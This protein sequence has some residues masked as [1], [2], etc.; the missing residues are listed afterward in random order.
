MGGSASSQYTEG[1]NLDDCSNTQTNLGLVIFANETFSE[2]QFN[3]LEILTFVMIALAALYC[4]RVWCEQRRRKKL[5][6]L[7]V[8]LKCK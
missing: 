2:Q 4:L 7:R 1:G 6:N 8:A 5:E 3:F